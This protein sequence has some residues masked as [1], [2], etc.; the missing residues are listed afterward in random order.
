MNH[1]A[2]YKKIIFFRALNPVHMGA[3]Q[4]VDHIDLPI[5]REQPTRYPIFYASGIKGALRQYAL[6][7]AKEKCQDMS[8]SQLDK[9]VQ[10]FSC[11]GDNNQETNDNGNSCKEQ[12]EILAKIFGSQDCKG[13]LTV[14]DAKIL[15]FPVKSL[16]GI[17]AYVT[18]PFVL[19]RYAEDTKN[20]NLLEEVQKIKNLSEC[21]IL[22]SSNLVLDGNKVVLEEFELIFKEQ[23]ICILKYLNLPEKLKEKIEP[24]VAVVSNDIFGYFVENFTE[25][26]NRIKVNPETGTVNEKS[27]WTEEY[28]PAESVLYSLW[29]ENERFPER[30]KDYLPEDDSLLI[31]GGDQT[32]GKGLV[33]IYLR[34]VN[35]ANSETEVSQNR[36]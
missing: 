9:A 32:V 23:P 29:F 25:V 4:G 1:N 15:F 27:L 13:G 28:L 26:V 18:C 8:L 24:R 20:D 36:P 11:E 35:D 31:L 34:E 2:E 17:F 6:E 30:G 22:A 7:K 3:G 5:Q 12:I 33:K 21:E 19:E 14:T 10:S 16:K